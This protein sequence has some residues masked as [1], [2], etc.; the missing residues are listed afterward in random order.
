ML[1]RRH[2]EFRGD[3]GGHIDAGGP[4]LPVINLL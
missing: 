1:S 4:G 2:V 3:L